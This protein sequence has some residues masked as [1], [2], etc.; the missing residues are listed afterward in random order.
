MGI[1]YK[2]PPTRKRRS[3]KVFLTSLFKPNKLSH[4]PPQV[5][6]FHHAGTLAGQILGEL[7]ARSENTRLGRKIANQPRT[8]HEL[9]EQLEVEQDEPI[10]DDEPLEIVEPSRGVEL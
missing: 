1:L 5:A 6:G 9:F 7:W 10:G 2:P 4:Y 3:R 8:S